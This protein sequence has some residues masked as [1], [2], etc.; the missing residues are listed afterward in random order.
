VRDDAPFE[1]EGRV[2][3]IVSGG[4]VSPAALVDAFRDVSR[5]EAADRLDVA[6]RAVEH[7]APVAE[8]VDDDPAT[9]FRAVVPAGTLCLLPV[10]LEDPVAEIAAHGEYFPEESAV[11]QA[12]ELAK[13]GQVELVLHHAML[14][15]GVLGEVRQFQGDVEAGRD[16]FLTVNV[17]AR[18]DRLAQATGAILRLLRIEV[19]RIVRVG[20]RLVEIRGPALDTVLCGEGGDLVRIA[21]DQDRIDDDAFAVGGNHA[22]LVANRHNRAD[23]MLVCAHAPG[24][25]VHDDTNTCRTHVSSPMVTVELA[26]FSAR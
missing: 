5:A 15:P 6:K 16:R 10:A 1:L 2:G 3:G 19:D 9:V 12:L 23:Q 8:H 14:D 25:A 11:D 22:A 26:T 4:G 18:R 7:V 24:D 20:Q 17:L 13:S 21:S